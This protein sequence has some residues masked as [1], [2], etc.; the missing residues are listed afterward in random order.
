MLK[1]SKMIVSKPI[2]GSLIIRELIEKKG[3]KA[4]ELCRKANKG[5]SDISKGNDLTF[6][7]MMQ[8]IEALGM[9]VEIR[10]K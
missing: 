5:K 10:E 8:Y 4:S 9:V 1:I 7:S 3:I 6:K 2:N